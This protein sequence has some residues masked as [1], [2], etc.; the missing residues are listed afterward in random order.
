MLREKITV[1]RSTRIHSIL[2]S[3]HTLF[4]F[5]VDCFLN[6]KQTI[7][8]C[9]MYKSFACVEHACVNELRPA[10]HSKPN[11]KSQIGCGAVRLG[12]QR[13]IYYSSAFRFYVNTLYVNN[14][15]EPQFGFSSSSFFGEIF[16]DYRR[17]KKWTDVFLGND[18]LLMN[19]LKV[20]VSHRRTC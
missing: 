16:I 12:A 5:V 19:R 18:D 2:I 6:D 8:I 1:Q 20:N 9:T 17:Q 11:E 14:R 4:W 3:L 15:T 13:A 7:I 10:E